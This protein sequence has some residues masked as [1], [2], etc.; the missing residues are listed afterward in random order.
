MKGNNKRIL[1]LILA[2]SMMALCLCGC[3]SVA[4]AGNSAAASADASSE[5]G[6]AASSAESSAEYESVPATGD[7]LEKDETVYVICNADGS[8]SKVIVSDW[9]KNGTKA[10]Q[11]T[12]QT[13]LQDLE[14]VKGNATYTMDSDNMTIWDTKSGDVFYKGTSTKDLP[15]SVAVS[16][17]LDG[18]DISAEDL[19]GKS[20]KVTIRFDYTNT[21]Y[22][23]VDV[24][25]TQT[26]IYVPFVVLTGMVLDNEK[27]SDIAVSNGKL[28][29]TGDDTMV[30]GFA[31]PG[32][33][34]SLN[35]SKDDL[36]IPDY[37]ELTADVTDFSLDTVMTLASAKFTSDV[38]D[39]DIS[40]LETTAG[41][42]NLDTLPDSLAQLTDAMKQLTDGSDELYTNMQTLL[43]K[44]NELATG[45]QELAAAVK[46]LDSGSTALYDGSISLRD[47][48]KTLQ[49][50]L[51]K[52]SGSSASLNAGAK[53]VFQSLLD[54]AN[55]QIKA[56]GADIPTLTIENYDQVL[57]SASLASSVSAQA[58]A[59]AKSQVTAAVKA[60]EGTIKTG[61]TAAVQQQVTQAVLTQLGKT[62]EDY[63]NISTAA[64]GGDAAATAAKAQI[65][66]AVTQQMNSASIQTTITQQTAAQEQKIIDQKMNSTEVTSAVASAVAQARQGESTLAALKTQLD[67]YNTFYQGLQTYTAGVDS[68]YAGSQ[69]LTAGAD[70]LASGYQTLSAAITKLDTAVA[71]LNTQ[72]SQMPDGV[73]KLTDG[74]MQ[75]SDGLQE[76]ND[77]GISKL[78]KLMGNDMT[79]LKDRVEA[80]RQVGDDYNN[81][82]GIAEGM[83]GSVQFVFKTASI[84]D[85]D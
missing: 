72:V 44:T 84:G 81:Y 64:A 51:G 24:N 34:D 78:E 69:K 43:E 68:A 73:S 58:N 74:A 76:L 21:Q 25:G 83:D 38:N 77:K 82:S 18:Q 70:Q 66:A 37:V 49:T 67:S 14:V 26:K 20:G 2:A 15:V 27:F 11:I 52:L 59:T 57:S 23:M 39:D 12:D 9:L 40:S 45:V 10:D 60:Q 16:Y 53:Q 5:S 7:K 79:G 55:A 28:V 63:T 4:A 33:Q 47:N 85:Q 22:E 8:V 32:M 61:V 1:A 42:D 54:Q 50:G 35:I 6:S 3:G 17:Q 13:D 46:Q 48:L 19:A 56:S 29:S 36:E 62:A 30:I 80:L 75:L 31:M 41:V 65:D 71:T